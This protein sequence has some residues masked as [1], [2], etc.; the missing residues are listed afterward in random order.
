MAKNKSPSNIL[1]VL[2]IFLCALLCAGIGVGAYL[3]EGFQKPLEIIGETKTFASIDGVELTSSSVL[4]ESEAL[5][6]DIVGEYTINII[7]NIDVDFD[8]KLDGAL[9]RF[10]GIKDFSKA[11]EV[12]QETDYFTL[13]TKQRTLEE[14]LEAM[15]P[16]QTASKLPEILEIKGLFILQIFGV[17]KSLSIT[18]NCIDVTYKPIENITLD[19]T[20][21]VF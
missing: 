11:F 17:E 2:A 6:I 7:R 3:T 10:S 9:M 5:R 18:L 14:I 19:K 4:P 15:F 12:V 8:F 20:E 16:G 1:Y 13:N 21:I